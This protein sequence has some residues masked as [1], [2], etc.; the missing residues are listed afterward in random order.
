MKPD[1]RK[2]AQIREEDLFEPLR[3]HLD[4]QGYRVRAEVGYCDV[5][6]T[7]GG[8]LIVI[9][10]KRHVSVDLLIQATDRQ[11]ITSS[12]YVAVPGPADF[13]RGSRWHGIK[14]VLR[15]LELGLIVVT[16]ARRGSRVE[17]LFHPLPYQRRKLAR[18]RRAVLREMEGRSDNHNRGGVTRRKLITAYR[19]TALRIAC[20][21]DQLGP[22][23]PRQLRGIGTGPK[24]LRILAD[25]H[26]GWFERIDRGVYAL[27][28][29]GRRELD[30]YNELTRRLREEVLAACDA[31]EPAAPESAALESAAPEPAA[32]EPTASA[33]AAPEPAAPS[34]AAL[35]PR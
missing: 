1:R 22:T 35:E 2:T 17:V 18:R 3:D 34:P 21:L 14:R 29:Q 6:A 30:S 8:E 24:T 13:S 28:G 23:T 5:T 26:Y 31:P 16:P 25:N 11:R 20:A 32:L 7:R 15:A 19:E 27:T 4:A 10:L 33:P 9:E 12:V